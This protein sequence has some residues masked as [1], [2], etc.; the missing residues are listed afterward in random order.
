MKSYQG[1]WDQHIMAE[2]CRGCNVIGLLST[3][4]LR[5]SRKRFFYVHKNLINVVFGVNIVFFSGHLNI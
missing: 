3:P 4:Y 5:I 2:Y 1:R